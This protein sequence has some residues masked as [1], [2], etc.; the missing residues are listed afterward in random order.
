V[1]VAD[2]AAAQEGVGG[3]RQNPVAD[4]VA[5]DPLPR[6]RDVGQ[7]RRVPPHVVGVHDDADGIGGERQG[8]VHG[9]AQAADHA[10]VGG[11]H[12]VQRLDAQPHAV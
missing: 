5:D 8:Q 10:A 12:R 6:A 4:L 11:E 9:L 3:E 1:P 7:Q 2:V